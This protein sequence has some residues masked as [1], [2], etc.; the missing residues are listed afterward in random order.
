[1]LNA[2][3]QKV[4][5]LNEGN[6]ATIAMWKEMLTNAEQGLQQHFSLDGLTGGAGDGPAPRMHISDPAA[7]KFD[8]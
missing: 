2:H 8:V 4:T 5:R 3:S 7:W 1:M 6:N